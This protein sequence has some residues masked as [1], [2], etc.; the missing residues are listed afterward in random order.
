MGLTYNATHAPSRLRGSPIRGSST[1]RCARLLTER[2]W[3]RVPPPELILAMSDAVI[4]QAV[5]RYFAL[6]ADHA[7]EELV[8]LFTND[9]VVIDEGRRREGTDAIRSWRTEVA[10]RYEYRTTILDAPAAEGANYRVRARL[11]GNFPGGTVELN[12]DFVTDGERI[13]YL[14]IAP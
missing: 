8:A 9:A 6:D 12:Y 2:L 3:V 11:D 7:V 5:R 10:D 13:K 14:K 4:P 1:G